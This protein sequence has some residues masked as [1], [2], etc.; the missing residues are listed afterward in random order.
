MPRREI[1]QDAYN[2][3]QKLLDLGPR[4]FLR[5]FQTDEVFPTQDLTRVLESTQ[6]TMRW[7][8]E[9]VIAGSGTVS[10]AADVHA[11]GWTAIRGPGDTSVGVVP[12][13]HDAL[14]IA[15]GM[16]DSGAGSYV[17]SLITRR[18]QVSTQRELLLARGD[19]EDSQMISNSQ[20]PV[21]LSPLPWFFPNSSRDQL[22]T[23]NCIATGSAAGTTVWFQFLVL[24]GPQGS[25]P[26]VMR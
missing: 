4:G 13:D 6:L 11:T 14:C 22:S 20:G 25:I 15:A 10:S 9:T 17:S 5:F 7:F 8:Q 26:R 21:I 16:K 19:T 3:I 18:T 12:A 2:R 23:L 24:S 1:G